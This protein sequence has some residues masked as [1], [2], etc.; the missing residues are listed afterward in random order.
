[1]AEAVFV[2]DETGGVAARLRKAIDEAGADWVDDIHEYD[3]HIGRR[4]LQ[5]RH[6]RARGGQD[7]IRCEREQFRRVP[8]TAV[9]I[10]RAPTVVDPHVTTGG[11]AQLLQPLRQRGDA[12]RSIV[13]VGG[14]GHQYADAPPPLALLRTRRER[15]RNRAAEQSDDLATVHS[16]TSSAATRSLSGTVSPSILAV[17]ALMT[18]SNFVACTTGNSAGLAPLRRRPT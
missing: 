1:R 16:I 15:P 7:N 14:E 2:Q 12:G 3:R 9:G 6:C 5:R 18:S 17:R 13:V 10:D 8:A 11:P 4:L